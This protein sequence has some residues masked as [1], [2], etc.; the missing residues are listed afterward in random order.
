MLGETYYFICCLVFIFDYYSYYDYLYC[1][2]YFFS[3]DFTFP[4]ITKCFNK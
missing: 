1:L 4:T 2:Y 3:S